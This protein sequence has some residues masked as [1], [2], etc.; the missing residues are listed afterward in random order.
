MKVKKIII[1]LIVILFCN[2]KSFSEENIYIKIKINNEIITNFDLEKERR[3]LAALNPNLEN[4][5]KSIQIRIATDSIAKEIIK[6][7]ELIKYFELDK[8]NTLV[9][10]FVKNFY[11][12]LGFTD[13]FSFN[14][15]LSEHGWT[16]DEV[17]KKIEIEALWNQLIFDKYK[18]QIKID[19]E[20]I[21]NKIKNDKKNKLK[22]SYNVSEI[23]FQIE[24]NKTF[25]DTFDSIEKSIVEIGFENTAN[26]YSISD[27][28]RIGGKI[29]WIEEDVVSKNLSLAL[30]KIKVGEYSQPVKINNRFV[31]LKINDKKNEERIIDE[32]REF[33]RLFKSE[34][35]RQLNNFSKIYFDKIKVNTKINEY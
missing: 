10:N 3:Y 26:L 16:L 15:Y 5:E 28:A 27:S 14:N 30:K 35:N 18:N 7:S 23:I 1:F 20:K 25:K 2:L 8:E 11:T 21:K 31:I 24:N 22:T 33:N 6:K 17:R 9:N 34:Q 13:E 12:N 19:A 29:G 4:I 32:K